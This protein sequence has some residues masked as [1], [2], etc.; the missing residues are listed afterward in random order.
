MKDLTKTVRISK[1]EQSMISFIIKQ[2][3]MER[4]GIL[5]SESECIRVLIRAGYAS[6]NAKEGATN[7]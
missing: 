6:I 4:N 1:N 2:Y 3:Q 7:E 5:I